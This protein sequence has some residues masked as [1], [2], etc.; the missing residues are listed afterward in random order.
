MGDRLEPTGPH[1]RRPPLA[2]VADVLRTT[3]AE[4]V[5]TREAASW[6]AALLAGDPTA[7]NPLPNP[8]PKPEPARR[9]R[10]RGCTAPGHYASMA[11]GM[12]AAD[13]GG[14]AERRGVATA[15]AA[16]A[17]ASALKRKRSDR[18]RVKRLP[19]AEP[20][21]VTLDWSQARPP[22]AKALAS[23]PP[24]FGGSE[25]AARP[26]PPRKAASAAASAS[27]PLAAGRGVLSLQL[28]LAPAA[29]A[30]DSSL[31][32]SLGSLQ[33]EDGSWQPDQAQLIKRAIARLPNE[34]SRE[35]ARLREE[36]QDEAYVVAKQFLVAVRYA[37]KAALV[38]KDLARLVQGKGG[39][40]R[41]VPLDV[42]FFDPQGVREYLPGKA[43]CYG[44]DARAPGHQ[45]HLQVP[46]APRC[47]S[48]L[49]AVLRRAPLCFTA[50]RCASRSAPLPCCAC[51]ALAFRELSR[52]RV[53]ARKLDA[54]H[55]SACVL[56]HVATWAGTTRSDAAGG[57]RV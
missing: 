5:G 10:A 46:A 12:S 34:L 3:E 57:H 7:P 13:G 4:A 31:P 37:A 22:G 50:P 16:S 39:T 26:P 32:L 35:A 33:N 18:P 27:T 36:G 38:R 49:P 47:A 42:A 8:K 41:F 55:A 1:W 20:R 53:R 40:E 56:L 15:A 52:Y 30:G 11:N 45:L 44:P 48:P 54:S 21:G 17:S 14:A 24:P 29:P 9:E 51:G 25:P 28:A 23:A 19:D 2:Q 6:L 43:V